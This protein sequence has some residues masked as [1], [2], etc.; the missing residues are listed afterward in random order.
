MPKNQNLLTTESRIIE[1][2]IIANHADEHSVDILN[3]E[4]N[5]GDEDIPKPDF[6]ARF[7]S[8]FKPSNLPLRLS[9]TAAFSILYD[10]VTSIL[11]V[12]TEVNTL[13]S[14]G[15]PAIINGSFSIAPTLLPFLPNTINL[16]YKMDDSKEEESESD[17]LE[18]KFERMQDA[19]NHLIS[20]ENEN[21]NELQI[22]FN[23]IQRF[24]KKLLTDL[25]EYKE[26]GKSG[27]YDNFINTIY[28]LTRAVGGALIILKAC[29]AE[30]EE[31][32]NRIDE[33]NKWL[34][35][36]SNTAYLAYMFAHY[37]PKPNCFA[38]FK[39]KKSEEIILKEN[40]I[41]N[42]E[43]LATDTNGL[44]SSLLKNEI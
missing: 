24:T 1:K 37:I 34:S 38:F 12:S 8:W 7:F 32:N 28:L 11:C 23:E 20:A 31:T 13:L 15:I 43:N 5:E 2:T 29:N 35:V 17:K 40:I 3:E 9:D 30:S 25:R 39:K 4:I 21:I 14:K 27:L 19:L 18:K 44:H 42:T 41:N 33:I 6:K 26:G 16:V 10:T 36:V 22:K